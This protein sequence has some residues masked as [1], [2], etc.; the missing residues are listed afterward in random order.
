MYSAALR[1]GTRAVF[2]AIVVGCVPVGGG[3][4]SSTTP[5]PAAADAPAPPVTQDASVHAPRSQSFEATPERVWAALPRAYKSVGL[6][7]NGVDT[8]T[9]TMGFAGIIRQKL[10]G[11]RLSTYFGCG[12]QMGENAD[13]YDITLYVASQVASNPQTRRILV[14]TGLRV[15]GRSPAFASTTTICTTKGELERRI[16][17]AIEEEVRRK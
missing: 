5:Q 3:P 6:T 15:S 17:A 2:L 7:V 4:T 11:V 13:T 9:R 16:M 12:N 1:A 8:V 10:G 14:T